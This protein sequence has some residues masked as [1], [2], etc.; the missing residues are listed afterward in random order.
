MCG[1]VTHSRSG[2]G[3]VV[4]LFGLEATL[5]QS[6]GIGTIFT[7]VSLV[8]GYLLRRVFETERK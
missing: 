6:L 3:P 5:Q 2:A 4:S 8:R 7:L 1:S